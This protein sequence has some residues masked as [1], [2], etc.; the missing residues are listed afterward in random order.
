[1]NVGDVSRFVLLEGESEYLF[2]RIRALL[3]AHSRAIENMQG[4]YGITRR[5]NAEGGWTFELD[6][7]VEPKAYESFFRVVD[8]SVMAEDGTPGDCRVG[9]TMGDIYHQ[10]WEKDE[11]DDPVT[12]DEIC[13]SVKI[14]GCQGIPVLAIPHTGLYGQPAEE[15][16]LDAVG[17]YRVWLHSWLG[18][19]KEQNPIVAD[20]YV[21]S[22]IIIGD[23]DD[24]TPPENPF[25][26]VA[27][28]NQCIGRV[29]VM[30]QDAIAAG[31]N[32]F[33]AAIP[34]HYYIAKIIQDYLRGGEHSEFIVA[35][36]DNKIILCPECET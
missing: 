25:M 21:H 34:A 11:N 27:W 12:N 22:R 5:K 30:H 28:A 26:G 9:V 2:G 13:G 29:V 32:G 6:R 3:N 31:P 7:V 4:D 33:P 14:N 19:T 16:V 17:T 10:S 35:Q 15:A 18:P 23:V 1:M 24:A 8:A 20:S 36:C